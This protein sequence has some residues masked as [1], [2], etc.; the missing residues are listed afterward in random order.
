MF[1]YLLIQ[2]FQ[3]HEKTR[4]DFSPGITTVIGPSDVGKSAVLRALRWVCA[5][6]PGGDAYIRHGAKGATVK[7]GVDGNTISRRRT[8]GG[9]VNEYHLNDQAF[10]AFGRG[11][12]EPILRLLNLGPVCWQGQ[13]DAPYWF[14]DTAGEVSR[15]LNTIVNL[16]VIDDVLARVAAKRNQARTRLDVA[17]ETLTAAKRAHTALDWV[18]AFDARLKGVEALAEAFAIAADRA[19]VARLLVTEAINTRQRHDNADSVARIGGKAVEKGAAALQ[20]QDRWATVALLAKQAFE[21]EPQAARRLPL[22]G[23]LEDKFKYM[24]KALEAKRGA[25]TLLEEA[26]K[27]KDT[28]CQAEEDLQAAVKAMPKTCPVCGK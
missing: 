15:Q 13:H 27:L 18:D 14:A 22:M 26:E 1:E 4:V 10:K 5:N 16:G 11:M 12:P 25:V 6:E 8:P 20:L 24:G 7:L 2:N 21:L 3:A 9:E 19:R 23:V 28:L 17:E